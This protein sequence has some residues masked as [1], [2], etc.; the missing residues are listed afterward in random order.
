MRI[1]VACDSSQ[2]VM[3]EQEKHITKESVLAAAKAVMHYCTDQ[4]CDNCLMAALCDRIAPNKG[5]KNE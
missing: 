1:L 4:K 5:G 3:K 2:A